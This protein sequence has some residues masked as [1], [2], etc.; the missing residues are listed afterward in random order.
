MDMLFNLA[1]AT[2]GCVTAGVPVVGCFSFGTK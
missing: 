2:L 1:N